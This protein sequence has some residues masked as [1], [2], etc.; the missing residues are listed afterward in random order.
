MADGDITG[1][2]ARY[3]TVVPASAAETV[4]TG[5]E[6]TLPTSDGFYDVTGRVALQNAANS[7]HGAIMVRA[8]AYVNDS[9]VTVGVVGTV[10]DV[11]STGAA[12][13]F[14]V[15]GTTLKLTVADANGIRV[16]GLLELFGCEFVITPA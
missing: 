10:H 6:I 7:V 12:V 14:D 13:N 2:L 16:V 1:R 15:T 8:E 3:G 9:A 4:I 11:G 5:C